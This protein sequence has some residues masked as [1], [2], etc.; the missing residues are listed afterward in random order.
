MTEHK[1]VT[2]EDRW[3]NFV[4][5]EDF[6]RY[7]EESTIS[8]AQPKF[9][10]TLFEG[11]FYLA[12]CTPPELYAKWELCENIA[13]QLKDKARRA[14]AGKY[15]HT[16]ESEILER[17]LIQLVQTGLTSVNEANW[18]ICRTAALLTWAVPVQA[19]QPPCN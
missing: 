5:P 19:A 7:E 13:L 11:K 14:S 1:T 15:A 16:T 2:D 10:A 9:N 8:G 17:Y 3:R 4:L 12:G 18:I 6:P